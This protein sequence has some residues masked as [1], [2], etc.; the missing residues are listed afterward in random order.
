MTSGD[1][2]E[3]TKVESDTHDFESKNDFQKNFRPRPD[4]QKPT[5]WELMPLQFE[6]FLTE[7][8]RKFKVVETKFHFASVS[9]R[10]IERAFQK[11]LNSSRMISFQN[12]VEISRSE[13]IVSWPNVENIAFLALFGTFWDGNFLLHFFRG[14]NFST[15]VRGKNISGTWICAELR[16]ESIPHI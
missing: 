8:D 12:R 10:A 15:N 5:D 2:C 3:Q 9:G 4:F 11:N 14:H 13:Q 16:A 6:F 7:C 1:H